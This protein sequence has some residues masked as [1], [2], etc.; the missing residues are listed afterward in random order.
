VSVA[1]HLRVAGA[2]EAGPSA[3][4]FPTYAAPSQSSSAWG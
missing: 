4:G 3:A 1:E 2:G